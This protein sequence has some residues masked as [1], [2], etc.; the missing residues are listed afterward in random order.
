MLRIG[1]KFSFVWIAR[2]SNVL[3]LSLKNIEVKFELNSQEGSIRHW[4]SFL[5][6]DWFGPK[7]KLLG[8]LSAE[9]SSECPSFRVKSGADLFL[10]QKFHEWAFSMSCPAGGSMWI[11]ETDKRISSSLSED[12]VRVFIG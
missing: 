3:N 8:H 9:R 4:M 5:R 1:R 6:L 2:C 12:P 7:R 10:I 11:Q